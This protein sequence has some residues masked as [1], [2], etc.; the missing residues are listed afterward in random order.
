MKNLS[1]YERQALDLLKMWRNNVKEG[2]VPRYT[3][4]IIPGAALNVLVTWTD[5][6][7]IRLESGKQKSVLHTH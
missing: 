7:I 4:D 3:C 2:G 5:Q 6:F 1:N